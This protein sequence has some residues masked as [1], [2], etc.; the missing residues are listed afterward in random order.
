MNDEYSYFCFKLISG[1]GKPHDLP[2]DIFGLTI[3]FVISISLNALSNHDGK[4]L[5]N[6]YFTNYRC[7]TKSPVNLKSSI[8][9]PLSTTWWR[10]FPKAYILS[11]WATQLNDLYSSSQNTIKSILINGSQWRLHNERVGWY[12]PSTRDVICFV[13]LQ[14]KTD[15][16]SDSIDIVRFTALGKIRENK[17]QGT[18]LVGIFVC[19]CRSYS[20]YDS[21]M[22]STIRL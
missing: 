13:S 5:C 4:Y 17:M 14:W 7:C 21:I 9:L 18:K 19:H 2:D 22:F 3:L 8:F 15:V 10:K 12:L 20:F 1:G 6:T 11:P 16:G